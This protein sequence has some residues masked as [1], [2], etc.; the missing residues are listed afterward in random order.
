MYFAV[1]LMNL[2]S[3]AVILVLSFAFIVQFSLPY[4]RV[5]KAKVL[6]ICILV[7]FWTF[8]GLKIVLMRP[9]IFKNFKI[10]TLYPS[11]LHMTMSTQGS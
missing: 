10:S 1:V 4:K 6:Y 9:V 8:Y 7:C 5:G 11:L 2:I 3:A